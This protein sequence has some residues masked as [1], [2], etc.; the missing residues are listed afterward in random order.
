MTF[1][2]KPR[3]MLNFMWVFQVVLVVKNP[4]A[5]AGNIKDI[6]LI[7]RLGRS[8][9]KGKGN[10][11]QYS[12]L[13]NPMDRGDRSNIVLPLSSTHPQSNNNPVE[14]ENLT[15]P[16]QNIGWNTAAGTNQT[17]IAV[18]QVS[19][20]WKSPPPKKKNNTDSHHHFLPSFRRKWINQLEK[21]CWYFPPHPN[22]PSPNRAS[23]CPSHI[24]TVFRILLSLI[25]V[26]ITLVLAT[27]FSCLD[28][29]D[30][31]LIPI[32]CPL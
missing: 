28:C 21:I 31:L 25:P 30:Y 27:V 12:C 2:I 5:S 10:P 13:E 22:H 8:P 15:R 11:L 29:P 26:T 23:S 9:W 18:K 14:K 17:Y 7:P 16:R 6:S 20:Q 3:T 19:A 24:Q 4:P 32:L 1:S